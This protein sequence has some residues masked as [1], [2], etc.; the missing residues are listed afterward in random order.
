VRLLAVVDTVMAVTSD[1]PEPA[2]LKWIEV[3]DGE[4]WDQV[5]QIFEPSADKL[6]SAGLDAAVMIRRGN[7]KDEI[8]EEAE[9]RKADCIFVGA[10]GMRGIRP[11]APWER[12][13]RSVSARTLLGRGR[14][15]PCL[16]SGHSIAG[17]AI[18]FRRIVRRKWYQ[19]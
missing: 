17:G 10:K 8:I 12:L 7:P 14:P 6:R 18:T 3:G 13:L 19:S 15:R 5:R 11:A 9:G 2:V 4:N 16:A 1:P